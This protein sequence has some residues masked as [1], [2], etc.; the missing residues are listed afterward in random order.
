MFIVELRKITG[1]HIEEIDITELEKKVTDFVKKEL[2]YNN[3][4]A[5]RHAINILISFYL[6]RKNN[7]KPVSKSDFVDLCTKKT[8]LTA[9]VVDQRIRCLVH[10]LVDY[11]NKNDEILR[12]ELTAVYARSLNILEFFYFKYMKAW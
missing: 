3:E 12:C 2:S 9:K 5:R 11:I 6:L 1:V 10:R 8:G 7:E 4:R